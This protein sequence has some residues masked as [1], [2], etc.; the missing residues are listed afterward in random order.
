M[1]ERSRNHSKTW[2]FPVDWSLT[3]GL[4]EDGT[5]TAAEIDD[6]PVAVVLG[7][8]D[9][10]DAAKAEFGEFSADRYALLLAR[11]AALEK[12][13]PE[14]TVW[15]SLKGM[16]AANMA[17]GGG[18]DMAAD[19][20][21]EINDPHIIANIVVSLSRK[22]GKQFSEPF[23]EALN[24]RLTPERQVRFVRAFRDLLIEID[25]FTELIDELESALIA[26]GVEEDP[27]V[28]WADSAQRLYDPGINWE[29]M[30]K[31]VRDDERWGGAPLNYR[32][33][34]EV[35]RSRLAFDIV[36]GKDTA[37]RI[38][39]MDEEI[40]WAANQYPIE[41][42]NLDHWDYTRYNLAYLLTLAPVQGSLESAKVIARRIK[43]PGWALHLVTKLSE[44]FD[45]P[46]KYKDYDLETATL[47]I[48]KAMDDPECTAAALLYGNWSDDYET[49]SNLGKRAISELIDDE[50]E[51]LER[52]ISYC[53]SCINYVEFNNLPAEYADYYKQR[54]EVLEAELQE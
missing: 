32:R 30:V 51:P 6:V 9:E 31:A 5:Q 14:R 52:R 11:F 7:L 33:H 54:K 50:N 36:A 49:G 22:A 16:L 10:L 35:R 27:V 23:I 12:Q 21:T 2:D 25:P 8:K 45:V 4:Q 26:D 34:I 38:A 41:D 46:A 20:A 19:L 13:Y 24:Q 47:D 3:G 37:E 1:T 17:M 42:P 40:Q 15:E 48:I 18:Y 43:N 44:L 29:A 28:G 53:Q 39:D